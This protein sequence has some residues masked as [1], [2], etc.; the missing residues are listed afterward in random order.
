MQ[1]GDP[2]ISTELIRSVAL[3]GSQAANEFLF[4]IASREDFPISNRADALSGLSA[5]SEA[6]VQALIKLAESETP[7]IRDEALRSLRFAP[8]SESNVEQL[9]SIGSRHPE[10]D[11]L[12]QATIDPSSLTDSRPAASDLEA[13]QSRLAELTTPVNL[14]AGRRLFHHSVVGTCIK[15]HRHSG[16]GS[17]LGPDLSASSSVDDP[18]RLLRALLQPSRDV[19]PQYHP[20]ML[21]T[22]DGRVFTGILL[23]DGGGGSEYYR[24]NLGREQRFKTDEIVQRKELN[25]SMMPEKLFEMM[26]DREIRDLLAFVG[27]AV[28]SESPNRVD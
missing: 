20:R 2:N 3:L 8:L 27:H 11:D 14:D 25:T 5:T 12:V 6:S 1:T 4:E 18:N 19:D 17:D 10:S 21:V 24:D 7:E 16:R 9:R 15:C 22:E 13:W 28:E 23:R 26:T